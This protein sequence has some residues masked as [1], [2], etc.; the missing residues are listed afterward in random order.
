MKTSQSGM[1]SRPQLGFS[2]IELMI[3][4]VIGLAIGAALIQLFIASRV[5]YNVSDGLARA[6]ESARYALEIM[7]RD[8]RMADSEA[9]CG[10]RSVDIRNW[11]D[12][13]ALAELMNQNPV[14]GWEYDGTGVE[15]E[16][17]LP[18]TGGTDPSDWSN[19]TDGLPAALASSTFQALAGSDVFAMYTLSPNRSGCSGCDQG[20]SGE[21]FPNI[22]TC[23]IGQQTGSCDA[24][25]PQGAAFLAVNCDLGLG[26]VCINVPKGT[27]SVLVCKGTEPAGHP[28]NWP[29]YN[30][31]TEFYQPSVIHYAVAESSASTAQ[32]PRQALWRL[33]NCGDGSG[34]PDLS[35]IR[36][37]LVDG[38][39]SLQIFYRV[40]N[41]PGLWTA[42]NI[43]GNRWDLV[44]A[45]HLNLIMASPEDADN[46][47]LAQT[48][49][50][51]GD[52][53]VTANDRRVRQ[54]Y[55]NVVAVRNRITVR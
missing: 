50:I 43:P 14:M 44:E 38:V 39:E 12:D 23:P 45:V 17:A 5:T 6:Q 24:G 55:S 47:A 21:V 19:G 18:A 2:L 11:V 20:K 41:E 46:R 48:L 26:D 31:E 54:V 29:P 40:R 37:E 52:L 1:F 9:I 35:C 22:P 4:M 28:G 13:P 34:S 7:N 53:E 8:I 32:R 33:I 30:T 10:N 49:L 36:E 15:E 25:I 51:E 27:A 3:A 42:A 16:L